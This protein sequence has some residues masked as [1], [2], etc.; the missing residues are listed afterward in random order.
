[1]LDRKEKEMIEKILGRKE[2]EMR[3]KKKWNKNSIIRK[4][5]E[6]KV[7]CERTLL[8]GL[9]KKKEMGEYAKVWGDDAGDELSGS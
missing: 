6:G 2:K 7:V 3:T 9:E 1:M 8:E 4:D 5:R